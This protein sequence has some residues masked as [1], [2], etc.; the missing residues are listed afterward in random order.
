MKYQIVYFWSVKHATRSLGAKNV[1]DT[2][3]ISA[4]NTDNDLCDQYININKSATR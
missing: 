4:V 2:Q 1:T 3:V